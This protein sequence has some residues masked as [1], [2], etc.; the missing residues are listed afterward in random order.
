MIPYVVRAKG[1][2]FLLCALL[3]ASVLVACGGDQPRATYGPQTEQQLLADV[4]RVRTAAQGHR[5]HAARVAL[6]RLTRHVAAAQAD[7]QLPAAKA[8]Q[9]L[10][11]ADLVAHDIAALPEPTLQ[12]ERP[13][14]RRRSDDRAGSGPTGQLRPH[15]PGPAAEPKDDDRGESHDGADDQENWEQEEKPEGWEAHKGGGSEGE[16]PEGWEAHKGED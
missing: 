11:A 13:T 8:R 12:Q 10:H 16:K 5:R 2:R 4:A 6:H 1:G 15:G 3:L 9:I 7:G 14:S